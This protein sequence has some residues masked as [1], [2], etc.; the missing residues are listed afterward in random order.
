MLLYCGRIVHSRVTAGTLSKTAKN[1]PTQLA[2]LFSINNA[3]NVS[4]HS[5]KTGFCTNLHARYVSKPP[6]KLS[7]ANYFQQRWHQIIHRHEHGG[8]DHAHSHSRLAFALSDTRRRGT[9]ITLIG[10]GANVGLAVAKGLAGWLMHSA[11]LVADAFHSLSDLASDFV[12]LYTFRTS[13]KP[14]DERH[15]Y[16]YGK[17]ETVGSL[18]VSSLLILGAVGIGHHSYELLMNVIN[19]N[20]PNNVS[21]IAQN[22]ASAPIHE[23]S[24]L[25][26]NAAWF[27]AASVVVNEALYRTTLKIG[28]EE[29]S[30]VLVA[31]AWHHRSDAA[32][33]FV[34][35]GAIGGSYLGFP[36]LDP[37]GGMLVAGMIMKNGIET[38]LVS[39]R[40]LVDVRVEEDIIKKVEEPNVVNFHSIRGRKSGPFHMVD[41]ILQVPGNISVSR[42]HQIEEQ[43]RKAVKEECESLSNLFDLEHFKIRYSDEDADAITV[44]N[45]L[46][47][48]EAVNHLSSLSRNQDKLVVRLF[49]EKTNLPIIPTP[50]ETPI[51]RKASTASTAKSAATKSTRANETNK[52]NIASSSKEASSNV[53]EEPT[54]STVEKIDDQ[55]ER[56]VNT[57][58]KNLQ[59][60]VQNMVSQIS[61]SLERDLSM[62]ISNLNTITA[63]PR[64]Q[65]KDESQS[66][67]SNKTD[68]NTKNNKKDD[69]K[70]NEIGSS[71][72]KPTET[73]QI[74]R[75][76]PNSSTEPVVHHG[77]ICDCCHQTI[78]GM[79]WK[80][81]TCPNFDLCQVCKSKAP[82]VHRHP[83]SHNF[84]PIPYPS[85]VSKTQS[86]SNLH[87]AICDYCE[88][89]IFGIRHKCINCPDFDLC[90]NCISLAPMQHPN[91]TFMPI[92]RPGEPEIKIPDAINHPGIRC[93]GCSKA[94]NGVRYKCGNCPDFDLCGN[95]EASP[96]NKHDENHVFIKI[97]KP[98]I[99]PISSREPL[100]QNFYSGSD[101]KSPR[102][103]SLTTL[104]E[105]SNKSKSQE[106][107][108]QA[109]PSSSVVTSQKTA[110]SAP[111]PQSKQTVPSSSVP[112]SPKVTQPLA[113]SQSQKVVPSSSSPVPQSQK[114]PSS[115][116]STSPKVTQPLAVSQSQK[117]APSSSTSTSQRVTQP[118]SVSQSQK[119]AS[120]SS[121]PAS[122]KAASSS[123]VS[124]QKS[125]SS[126]S[127]QKSL[128][129]VSSQKSALSAMREI[130]TLKKEER[131]FFKTSSRKSSS[132]SS[133]KTEPMISRA[134][135]ALYEPSTVLPPSPI[136]YR[137]Q[138]SSSSS[139]SSR[140]TKEVE[141]TEKVPELEK[142]VEPKA[143]LALRASFIE[144]VNVPDGT[145]LP[146]QAQFLKIWKMTNDG[147]VTWPATTAL[148]FVGGQEMFNEAHLKSEQKQNVPQFKVGPLE[149]NKT[150]CITADLQAPAE[151]GRYVSYW[152]LTDGLGVGNRFGHRV[153]CDIIVEAAD[154]QSSMSSS[155]IF[156]ILTYDQQSI[157]IDQLS[158][159]EST[160]QSVPASIQTSVRTSDVERLVEADEDPFQ[161]P[162]DDFIV[163]DKYE[164]YFE[165]ERSYLN[166]TET[167]S[168][169]AA[170]VEENNSVVDH[171]S[172][173]ELQ[174]LA[175]MV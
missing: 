42:A 28:I 86:T 117:A 11:S 83:S 150:V 26:P 151:P 172:V 167:A 171:N 52:N 40:E 61:S 75:F 33:S 2:T 149:P 112:T 116:T 174:N 164:K 159:S 16:G 97:K 30:D 81:Q 60:M 115:S 47:L 6:I 73:Q 3:T 22:I 129:S 70:D 145:V 21:E 169:M 71:T 165:A 87:S 54:T 123:T 80:C 12:T 69:K 139:L 101:L 13:R 63:V 127:S 162:A 154:Q 95:C 141:K 142:A 32:S 98:V 66:Q 132:Q 161:D 138:S 100:L 96:L 5:S 1:I 160:T 53:V 77:I 7:A 10:L 49:L 118:S 15:P 114:V 92:H 94:I 45:D 157:S 134:P 130:N 109:A 67:Q 57:S 122:Q 85:H 175:E 148:Q 23:N 128:S 25:N 59:T 108:Q 44:E 36:L 65:I 62:S 76:V 93:D 146:S 119:T 48:M 120:I 29:R 46:D 158:V 91:H 35:L 133:E 34:A 107:I 39:L 19:L 147:D 84:R 113:V 68:T 155:M 140:P 153:W 105:I 20:I 104:A 173:V 170:S 24:K 55:I 43:V 18:A 111:A 72:S 103:K 50:T 143:N 102:T 163:V 82:S 41:M 89:V 74:S 38:M 14:A 125:L 124:S 56:V 31:N 136:F 17:Y 51:T 64:E 168:S 135:T 106:E 37:I 166:D 110:Q 9:R 144:D 78:Q 152:R 137:T 156:P 90:S 121:A 131:S 126:V 27:A 99:I 88:S 58:F 4:L 79:R 8:E